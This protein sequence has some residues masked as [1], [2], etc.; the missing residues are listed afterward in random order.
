MNSVRRGG[1][2]TKIDI[3]NYDINYL[4]GQDSGGCEINNPIL[5]SRLRYL[6]ADIQV[7]KIERI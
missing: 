4:M 3:V 2:D 7:G 5:K 1:S 6:S